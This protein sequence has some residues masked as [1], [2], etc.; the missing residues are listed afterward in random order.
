ML[1]IMI[2]SVALLA[3]C[4][5]GTREGDPAIVS[6]VYHFTE[7]AFVPDSPAL[8]AVNLLDTLMVG[9]TDLVLR[10]SGLYVLQYQFEGSP[11]TD[12]LTGTF[13]V[14]ERR[15]RLRGDDREAALYSRILLGTEVSFNRDPQEPGILST[16]Q[17][18]R[19]NLE[20]FSP[21]YRGLPVVD[22]TIRIRLERDR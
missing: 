18:R 7:F 6:G 13:T 5:R 19:V 21:R 4:D 10:S 17:R 9:T 3:G 15:V 8:P 16:E 20:A 2:G 1:W 12:L 11:R 22:G 14:Q